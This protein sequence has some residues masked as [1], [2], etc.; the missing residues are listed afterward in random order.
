MKIL[1]SKDL[2]QRSRELRN[3]KHTCI[4]AVLGNHYEAA[5]K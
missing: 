5:E 1:Y 4:G 2:K 3:N